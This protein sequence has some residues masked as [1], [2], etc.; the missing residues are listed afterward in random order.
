M[1]IPREGFNTPVESIGTWASY[2]DEDVLRPASNNEDAEPGRNDLAATQTKEQSQMKD[3]TGQFLD[4]TIPAHAYLYGLIQTDGHLAQDTRNRGKL[5]L[6]MN[7]KDAAILERLTAIIPYHSHLRTRTRSTNFAAMYKSSILTVYAK[8]FRDELGKLGLMVG[9]KSQTVSAPSVEYVQADYFRGIIDGDGSL[10]LTANQFP[11]LALC[12]ASEGLATAYLAF[13]E[14][15]TGKDKRLARNTR[16]G[17][18]NLTLYKEDAQTVVSI[19]YYESCLAIPRKSEAAKIIQTWQRPDN[20]RKMS[21]K[22]FWTDEQDS[23]I[24]S[25][26]VEESALALRRTVQSV[27]MRLWRLRSSNN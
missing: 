6:E 2:R 25:H 22:K 23:Y 17:V 9:R 10:G 16:D 4:L 13:V 3:K 5:R 18:F 7:E 26:S 19:L 20:M 12:T 15:L 14:K 11:F 1:V 24:L 8:E 21:Q 27:K